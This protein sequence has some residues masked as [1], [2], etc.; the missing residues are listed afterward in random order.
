M[1]FFLDP[2]EALKSGV[3]KNSISTVIGV[4]TAM[5]LA[6]NA[7]DNLKQDEV[8]VRTKRGSSVREHKYGRLK[9]N[10]KAVGPGSYLVMPVK[11]NV[12]KVSVAM[13]T[14]D[15]GP[16]SWGH[17]NTKDDKRQHLIDASVNWQLKRQQA[18]LFSEIMYEKEQLMC[19]SAHRERGELLVG[20][21]IYKDSDILLALY[22]A[23]DLEKTL[24]KQWQSD[25]RQI[26]FGLEDPYAADPQPLFNELLERSS[27]FTDGFGVEMV[28]LTINDGGP[29]QY[30]IIASALRDRAVTNDDLM[31]VIGSLGVNGKGSQLA[32]LPTS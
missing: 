32:E 30:Q 6:V 4:L 19:A 9:G 28:G 27:S 7:V 14:T 31:A 16:T 22:A 3:S 24:Q 25:F 15:L 11:G 5:T 18:D 20:K 13:H 29:D 23:T 12:D 17:G 10:A 21:D 8:G 2:G 1:A 26:C